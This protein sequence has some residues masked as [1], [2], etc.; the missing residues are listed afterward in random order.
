MNRLLPLI[1]LLATTAQA[2]THRTA[3]FV[4]DAADPGTAFSIAYLAEGTRK[5]VA[6]ELT[7]KDLGDWKVPVYIHA[8]VSADRYGYTRTLRLGPAMVQWINIS[9]TYEDLIQIA[10]HEVCH[11]VF[12]RV[13]DDPDGPPKWCDEGLAVRHEANPEKRGSGGW[14]CASL[15][16]LFAHESYPKAWR[17]FYN[18]SYSV[19]E[20]L[21]D[22]HGAG[23]FLDF[24]RLGPLLTYEVAS[25]VVYGLPLDELDRRWRE[26]HG[27]RFGWGRAAEAAPT[28]A[29]E[30]VLPRGGDGP[31][32]R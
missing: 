13:Y 10:T 23:Q 19:T 1:L 17:E 12:Y 32:P 25:R 31:G 30:A 11:T 24:A 7:G 9:G 18:Q 28:P 14:G 27:S 6:R 20:F 16:R 15:P 5:V 3:N 21:I 8:S 4:V 22:E 26:W 29:R 2:A